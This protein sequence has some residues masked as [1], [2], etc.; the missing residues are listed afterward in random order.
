LR[1]S[2]PNYKKLS[3]NVKN[4]KYF[5]AVNE[6]ME[7]IHKSIIPLHPVKIWED[8]SPQFLTTFWSLTM[9]DLYVP[10]ETYQQVITK[11]RQQSLATMESSN[12]NKGKKEQERYVTLVEKLQD[13][14]KKQHEHVE[15]VMYRLR[16]EKD[17]WF[18]SR[19]A[20]SAKN[21]T[22]TRFLQLCL[23]PRCTFTSIDA[24]YCAK[25]VHV[26]HMLKTPNFSTLLCYDRVSSC[27]FVERRFTVSIVIQLFCD[28]T[29]SITSCSEN[30]A[31]RYGRFLYAMLE[32]VMRWHKSKELFDRECANYP[33][34]VTKYRLNNQ[35]ADNLDNVGYENYRHVCHKWHYKLAKAMVTCLD[36]KDYVQIRNS[37]IILIKIIPFFPVL[38][39]VGQFIEKRIEK[40]RDEEKNNRQ[41][42][43]TLSSSYLGLLKQRI[44]SGHMVKESDFHILVEKEK[45]CVRYFV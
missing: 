28:V 5:E 32:T 16:Q 41:D 1:K 8:I 24:V 42:L 20:K 36:S 19:S 45:V 37:L 12:N 18:L 43:F 6:V 27:Q 4:Q 33:G 25:F 15:K 7:P 29:Y 30:E 21:E 26:I 31:M 38:Q 3:T 11:T 40:V 35:H 2:D 14:K 44:M 39:K 34:F 10:D 9:Y 22:I 23:F 17:S 13:E